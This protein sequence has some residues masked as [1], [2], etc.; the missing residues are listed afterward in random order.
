MLAGRPGKGPNDLR[1]DADSHSML[2]KRRDHDVQATR[3]EGAADR[4]KLEVHEGRSG[5][6]V[7]A[8]PSVEPCSPRTVGLDEPVDHVLRTGHSPPPVQID[9]IRQTRLLR[10]VG[11]SASVTRRLARQ[12]HGSDGNHA[13]SQQRLGLALSRLTVV[14]GGI[15]MGSGRSD[16]ADMRTGSTPRHP[17]ARKRDRSGG[18]SA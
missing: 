13:L 1:I 11:E 17:A 16:R 9:Q 3:L 14:G 10:R 18:G 2:P 5:P 15:P 8:A 12:R 7:T 6:R 4:P